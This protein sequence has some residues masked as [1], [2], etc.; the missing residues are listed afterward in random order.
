VLAE[1][2]APYFNRT[3]RHFSSH[4]H[5]PDDPNAAPLGAAVTIYGNVAYVAYPI[6]AM[7][8]A[9]GQPLYKY[10]VR[11]LLRRL[12]PAPRACHRSPVGK[13]RDSDPARTNAAATYCICSTVPL[14][15][16]ASACRTATGP[17][18][19]WR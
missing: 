11:G 7:Y 14:R 12:L 4:R 6:F 19:S 15:Y 16:A 13:P 8:Q 9:T 10:V 5:T 17:L 3:Y 18:G 2:V 1:V